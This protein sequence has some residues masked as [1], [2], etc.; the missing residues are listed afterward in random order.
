MVGPLGGLDALGVDVEGMDGAGAA[1]AGGDN[2]HPKSDAHGGVA[3]VMHL[4]VAAED[5]LV[6]HPTGSPGHEHPGRNLEIPVVPGVGAGGVQVL[7]GL[8]QGDD[9]LSR[10]G[11]GEADPAGVAHGVVLSHTDRPAAA[12]GARGMGLHRKIMKIIFNQH[13]QSVWLGAHW[14]VKPRR[15]DR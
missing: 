4:D 6:G 13:G 10:Q 5:S 3:A 7:L 14:R 11:F 12:E 8:V 9:S 15:Q 1:H 2:F